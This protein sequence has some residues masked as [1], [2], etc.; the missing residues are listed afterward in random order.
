LS[1]TSKDR[2]DQL[3]AEAWI[4]DAVLTLYARSRILQQDGTID[5]E[6]CHRLTSNHFLSA[7]GEPTAVEAAIGR[8]YQ[9]QGLDAA[10]AHIEALLVPAFEKREEKLVQK[11]PRGR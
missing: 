7:F 11:P 4:G 9:Q 1:L 10:F 6:K 2:S 3:R 5:A 8:V